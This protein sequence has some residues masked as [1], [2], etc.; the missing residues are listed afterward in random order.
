M[1]GTAVGASVKEIE[2]AVGMVVA[3]YTPFRAIRAGKVIANADLPSPIV[4]DPGVVLWKGKTL[5]AVGA[6]D[7]VTLP[8]GDPADEPQI[9]SEPRSSFSGYSSKAKQ[10]ELVKRTSLFK[11]N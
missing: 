1:Y 3:H 7:E 4:Y 11:R 2:S 6:P 5:V 9:R 8:E 10:K